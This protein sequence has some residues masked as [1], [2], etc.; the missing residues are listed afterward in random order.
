MIDTNRTVLTADEVGELLGFRR[1]FIYDLCR[2]GEIPYKKIG[3]RYYRFNRA[4]I[5]KWLHEQG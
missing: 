4:D 3:R 1:D 5:E 2:R